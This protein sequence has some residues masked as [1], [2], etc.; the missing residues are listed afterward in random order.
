[1][2]NKSCYIGIDAGKKGVIA[3][4]YQ[5][6]TIEV[7]KIPLLQNERID[8]EQFLNIIQGDIKGIAIEKQ[9]IKKEQGHSFTIGR[10]Y[11]ELYALSHIN[12]QS[13][14]VLTR[15]IEVQP[16]TWQRAFPLAPR[17]VKRTKLHHINHVLNLYPQLKGFFSNK[18]GDIIKSRH[19][20]ADAILIATWLKKRLS[21]IKK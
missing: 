9:F 4:L 2:E 8:I 21:L 14:H 11:G 15:V 6:N 18:K 17:G 3:K 5:D 10:N 1:M 19:D 12:L 20:Y 16:I 13:P 7:F